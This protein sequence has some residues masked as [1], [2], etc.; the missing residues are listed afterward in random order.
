MKPA[1]PSEWDGLTMEKNFRG[2]K[3][4]ITVDNT[5]HKQGNPEKY[6]L[7]G[8]ERPVAVIPDAELKDVNELTVVM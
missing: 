1:I 3:L 5:A 7:N 8:Q 2:R 4:K 6:I